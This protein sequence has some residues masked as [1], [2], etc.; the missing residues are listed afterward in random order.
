VYKIEGDVQ[1]HVNINT[2][3]VQLK[4]EK[5]IP[6]KAVFRVEVEGLY[7]SSL[8]VWDSMK[9]VFLFFGQKKDDV[10]ERPTFMS[11]L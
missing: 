9:G 10:T 6:V 11:V 8:N 1:E 7:T 5:H 2:A 3:C 4:T